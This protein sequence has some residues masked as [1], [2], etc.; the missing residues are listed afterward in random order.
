MGFT[1]YLWW[2]ELDYW[3]LPIVRKQENKALENNLLALI[4]MCGKIRILGIVQFGK[5]YNKRYLF[6]QKS[7]QE[8]GFFVC[9][10]TTMVVEV[11]HKRHFSST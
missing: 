9:W 5:K 7:K 10:K 4:H 2:A 11:P 1:I 6:V 3:T 8:A